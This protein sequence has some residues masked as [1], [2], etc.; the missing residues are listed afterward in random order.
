MKAS[1]LL[2][3]A[4]I[5]VTFCPRCKRVGS[6]MRPSQRGRLAPYCAEC[7]GNVVLEHVRYRLLEGPAQRI[8]SLPARAKRAKR[9]L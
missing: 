3:P 8:S 6:A 9:R 7:P 1:V 5:V 4:A 2:P